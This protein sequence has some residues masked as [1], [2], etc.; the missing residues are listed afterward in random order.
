MMADNTISPNLTPEHGLDQ[1][2]LTR[3][4][5]RPSY[6]FKSITSTME[7]AKQLAKTGVSEGTVVYADE[8]TLGRGRQGRAWLSPQGSIAISI[9]LRPSIHLLPQLIMIASVAIVRTLKA[10]AGIEADIKWPNDVL[11]KGKKVCGI[12]IENELRGTEINFSVIGIGLNVNFNVLSYPE[13]IELATSISHE[14]GH[15]VCKTGVISSVLLDIER[16][17]VNAQAGIHPY[18][19]WETHMETL[20]KRIRINVG[21]V[22]KEGVAENVTPNGNLMLRHVDGTLSEISVGDVTVLKE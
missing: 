1:Y 15:D 11:V 6:Y 22:V 18:K 20:G 12:L 17:Y 9:V 2:L 13:I 5:G 7:E 16:L 3:F 8:Q 4:I 10:V 14:V 19:E 21:G